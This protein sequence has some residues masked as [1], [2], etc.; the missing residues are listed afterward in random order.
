GFAVLAGG[1]QLYEVDAT[2]PV[3][4]EA[5]PYLYVDISY[6]T[7]LEW[8]RRNRLSHEP[9]FFFSRPEVMLAWL[10]VPIV[11][12]VLHNPDFLRHPTNKHALKN[13][14]IRYHFPQ[15]Q[16]RNKYTGL[17]QVTN[18]VRMVKARLS[19]HFG[20]R[21]HKRPFYVSE[22]RRQLLPRP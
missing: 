10:R 14:V 5:D 16:W 4:T 7:P 19:E 13:S 6:T 11:D 3:L 8:C 17:E 9:F 21:I 18:L 22:L 12:F 1:E 15:Q 20:D 2:K